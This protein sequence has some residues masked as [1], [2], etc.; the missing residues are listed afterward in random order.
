MAGTR[1]QIR[2]EDALR[3]RRPVIE[4]FE[5]AHL[6]EVSDDELRAMV[7]RGE[8]TDA[9]PGRTC[10]VDPDELAVRLVDRPLALAV[11]DALVEGRLRLRR[12][13]LPPSLCSTFRGL[14]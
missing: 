1:N 6:L 12:D 8:L 2:S 14:S 7:R 11:L 9:A 13:E 5:A 4:V 10:A 3:W